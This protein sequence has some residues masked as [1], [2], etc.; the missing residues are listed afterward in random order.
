ML[1]DNA[2][3]A[4]ASQWGACAVYRYCYS[5]AVASDAVYQTEYARAS[6]LGNEATAE[7]FVTV[8]D[9]VPTSA[10]LSPEEIAEELNHNKNEEE[11]EEETKHTEEEEERPVLST[12][13]ALKLAD[14]LRHFLSTR[15]ES[16]SML[17][18]LSSVELFI[19]QSAAAEM[20]QSSLDTFFTTSD[21]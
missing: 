21:V 15:P 3:A 1:V 12:T 18:K 7:E 13:Q 19:R 2:R 11:D 20:T 9:D 6:V 17:D 16:G 5:H 4:V 10:I 14:T 8:D